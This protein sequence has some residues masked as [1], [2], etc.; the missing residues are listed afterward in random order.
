MATYG[1]GKRVAGAT[2]CPEHFP[3]SIRERLLVLTEDPEKE[4]SSHLNVS[5]ETSGEISGT[6]RPRFLLVSRNQLRSSAL[7]GLPAKLATKSVF[8]KS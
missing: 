6:L 2:E 8:E 5:A 1:T 4:M 7:N 3:I